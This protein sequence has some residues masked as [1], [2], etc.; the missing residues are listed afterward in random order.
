MPTPELGRPQNAENRLKK[1][2]RTYDFLDKLEIEYSRVDHEV[3]DTMEACAEIDLILGAPTCK[4]L[5]LTNRQ[6]TMFYL[7]LIPS[8]KPF[9]TKDLSAQIGS[10]R[11][12]FAGGED[13]E[14]MLDITPG[15]LSV[16]GLINDIDRDVNLLIDEELLN[17]EY[18]GFHPCINTTT[19]KVKTKDLL[20]K[21]YRQQVIL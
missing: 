13:M 11:L 14:R 6:R 1:E 20:E 4:N 2:I 12:S 21:L 10:A 9:K 17:N 7:L 19:L 8:D 18:I 3:T 5:F 16:M 15:S